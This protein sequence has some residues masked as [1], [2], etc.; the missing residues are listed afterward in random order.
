MERTNDK[1]KCSRKVHFKSPEQ[2]FIGRG[3]ILLF[4]RDPGGDDPGVDLLGLLCDEFGQ[5]SR[6]PFRLPRL[7]QQ[8]REV[9]MSLQL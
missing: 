6:S 9:W 3:A 5:Q 4:M 8:V 1:V 7:Q 2:V